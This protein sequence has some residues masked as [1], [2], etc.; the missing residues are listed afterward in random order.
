VSSYAVPAPARGQLRLKLVEVTY[1]PAAASKPH[2]HPCPVVGY[3]VEGVLRSR[4]EGEAEAAY[5][6][7]ES[8][9]ERANSVHAVSANASGSART[10]L[11]AVFVCE[12][13]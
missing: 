4:V 1:G 12:G 8:F 9:Y 13:P 6:A 2:S 3:V 5:R 7:G 10:K 11:L